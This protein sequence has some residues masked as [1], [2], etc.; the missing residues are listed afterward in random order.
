M[1]TWRPVVE[2]ALQSRNVPLAAGTPPCS[3]PPYGLNVMV[4]SVKPVEAMLVAPDKAVTERSTGSVDA[5]VPLRSLST[6]TT[7]PLAQSAAEAEQLAPPSALG[8]TTT[9]APRVAASLR[10][11]RRSAIRSFACDPS[12]LLISAALKFGAATASRIAATA[13]TTM[14]SIS[15]K[16]PERRSWLA[17]R[18]SNMTV[19]KKCFEYRQLEA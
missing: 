17:C 12:R 7:R 4:A 11:R 15:V 2:D 10:P 13:T 18:S 16:P 8:Q 6:N 1:R 19:F 5:L 9:Q 14:S 3:R